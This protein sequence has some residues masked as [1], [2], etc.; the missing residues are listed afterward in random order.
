MRAPLQF[1]LQRFQGNGGCGDDAQV[2]AILLAG[3]VTR[4]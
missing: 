1:V 4:R 3:A 2:S